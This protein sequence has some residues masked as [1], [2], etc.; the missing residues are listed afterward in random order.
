MRVV[1][2]EMYCRHCHHHVLYSYDGQLYHAFRE[3]ENSKENS[4]YLTRSCGFIIEDERANKMKEDALK[5]MSERVKKD[6]QGYYELSYWYF[7]I[8]CSC[9]NPEL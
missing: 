3:Q 9:K 1:D 8:Q 6:Y 4:Y 5:D 7:D 2:L